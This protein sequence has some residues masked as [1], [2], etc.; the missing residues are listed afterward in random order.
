MAGVSDRCDSGALR[1]LAADSS[2]RVGSRARGCSGLDMRG[3]SGLQGIHAPIIARVGQRERGRGGRRR[4]EDT[5]GE[6]MKGEW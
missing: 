5:K 2:S 3:L 4:G 1:W 6:D